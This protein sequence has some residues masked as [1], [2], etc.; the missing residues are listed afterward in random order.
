[1]LKRLKEY[2]PHL[3]LSLVALAF[4]LAA[5]AA[6]SLFTRLQTLT[7]WRNKV[8]SAETKL[9][10]LEATLQREADTL[11]ALQEADPLYFDHYLGNMRLCRLEA[12]T[13]E[14]AKHELKEEEKRRLD[15]LMG[16]E[17]SLHFRTGKILKG[18]SMQA[19]EMVQEHPVEVEEKDVQRILAHLEGMTIGPYTFADHRPPMAIKKL[20]LKRKQEPHQRYPSYLF[21]VEVWRREANHP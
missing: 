1:M 2:T 5:F 4:F 15:F 8:L 14:T 17:N 12:Y 11:S 6:W 13:L 7:I 10:L 9:P 21:E 18:T 19:I 3:Y 16:P 20:S